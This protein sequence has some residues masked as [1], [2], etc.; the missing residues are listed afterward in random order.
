MVIQ[1]FGLLAPVA[2]S[3]GRGG[4]RG[5]ALAPMAREAFIYEE[6]VS[7]DYSFEVH[8]LI[9]RLRVASYWCLVH[10]DHMAHPP[11]YMDRSIP[12]RPTPGSRGP[13]LVVGGVAPQPRERSRSA[14]GSRQ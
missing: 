6:S 12:G 1:C 13:V 11:L 2:G 7:A 5:S 4:S 10:F 3:G 9:D 14:R 8:D